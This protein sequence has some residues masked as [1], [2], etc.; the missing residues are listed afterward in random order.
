MLTFEA[1]IA[2]IDK[3]VLYSCI[4]NI[5]IYKYTIYINP[6]F[7]YKSHISFQYVS[8]NIY[9]IYIINIQRHS[10]STSHKKTFQKMALLLD[11]GIAP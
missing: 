4:V 1:G 8:N 11:G 9:I 7:V 2:N 6:F 3:Y 10:I 5:Y